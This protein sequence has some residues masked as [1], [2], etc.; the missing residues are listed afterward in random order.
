MKGKGLR[1]KRLICALFG[2]L[3]VS[4]LIGSQL[5]VQSSEIRVKGSTR[6]EDT[7]YWNLCSELEE[8]EEHSQHT[9]LL[10]SEEEEYIKNCDII[11]IGVPNGE[12]PLSYVDTKSK[13]HKGITIDVLQTLS[14]K[15]GLKFEFV[16][17]SLKEPLEEL[18]VSNRFDLIVPLGG[19]HSDDFMSNIARLSSP[20]YQ[21]SIVLAILDDFKYDVPNFKIGLIDD[22]KKYE[23]Y[24]LDKYP[25]LEIIS[26]ETQKS[27]LHALESGEIKAFAENI[28]IFDY[29]I[30][31]PRFHELKAMSSVFIGLDYCLLQPITGDP[32]L[33]EIINKGI[34]MITGQETATIIYQY[35]GNNI[36]EYSFY[37]YLYLYRW[38]IV[39]VIILLSFAIT[40]TLQRKRNCNN[41]KKVNAELLESNKAKTKFLSNIS[42]EIRTPMNA[43]IGLT[44]ICA[45]H[46]E[47]KKSLKENLDKIDM[48]AHYLLS[49]INDILDISRIESGKIVLND[50]VVL[51]EEFIQQ[52][53]NIME[54][55]VEDKGI[56]FECE[57]DHSVAAYY[58]FDRL[59]L[60]QVII[61]I[62]SNA[63]KFTPRNGE[64]HFQVEQMEVI[65]KTATLSFTITDTGIG[66]EEEFLPKIFDAFSQEYMDNTTEYTG[67]GLGLAISKNL[68]NLFHGDI[69]VS[70][71]K[72]EGTTFMIKVC[73]GVAKEYHRLVKE[74]LKDQLENHFDFANKKVL[75]VE[76]NEINLEVAKILLE[77][78]GIIVE[79]VE[80]GQEAVERFSSTKEWYYSAILMD[81]R[82][83]IMDGL[84]AT[85]E[86]RKLNKDDA[87]IIPIIA[88]TANAFE[89]DVKK[90]IKAGMNCHLAKP[91]DPKTL[92]ETL[93]KVMR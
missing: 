24:I 80:N 17:Y 64:I 45:N 33:F 69:Q 18:V 9:S 15:L 50:E 54:E 39:A 22:R 93:A 73:V 74:T 1:M 90:S 61:N 6:Q 30:Q 77:H 23:P 66:I 26:Y 31:S 88:M 11:T 37:D 72:G 40:I 68:V 41:M 44:S 10:T 84:D 2:I 91:I 46:L 67:S 70:S 51:F 5:L 21:A 47:D 25:E 85:M 65:D 78:V 27:A 58:I 53:N 71:H 89:E 14:R 86:I 63:I 36:Y 52:I 32:E 76:D 43:I 3:M 92:Y 55:R 59:R 8:Q 16:S 48:S 35:Q 81:I 7:C 57:V 12:C 29:L 79:W 19:Q 49:L 20:F 28:Y 13:K 75:L 42:H 83:P 34:D 4:I 82:M 62:L 60:Q 38:V 56:R 87:K